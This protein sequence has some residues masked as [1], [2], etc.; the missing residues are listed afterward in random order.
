MITDIS[1]PI[2][3]HMAIY[4][5]NPAVRITTI[6]EASSGKTALSE[7]TLG[8]HT[9]THI[10]APSHIHLG[11]RGVDVYPL[12]QLIGDA[13]LVEID[14][15]IETINGQDIPPTSCERVLLKTKNSQNDIDTFEDSFTALSEDGAQELLRRNIRLIG[16]D[17][18]SIKKRGV[19]DRVHELLLDAG[20]VV[21]EGLYLRQAA[22]GDYRLICLPLPV[23][24]VDGVPV[25]AVLDSR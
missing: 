22:I 4:P 3:P 18:F 13:Q 24:G 2:H 6:R 8:S 17:G 12:E 16:I 23:V 5:Q 19:V 11:G 1:R 10:D 15:S 21:I 14:P 7:I 25:R 20:V 9:G